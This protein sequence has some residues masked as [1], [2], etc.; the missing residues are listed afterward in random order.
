MSDRSIVQWHHLHTLNLNPGC[1]FV[2]TVALCGLER[3]EEALAVV[4]EGIEVAQRGLAADRDWSPLP[5]DCDRSRLLPPTALTDAAGAA[6][7]PADAANTTTAL[8]GSSSVIEG[9]NP[10][11]DFET[12]AARDAAQMMLDEL[13]AA[14]YAWATCSSGYRQV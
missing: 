2:Q 13:E 9:H 8:A 10:A 6:T 7:A 14:R 1:S 11:K 3:F 5:A 12:A 4:N